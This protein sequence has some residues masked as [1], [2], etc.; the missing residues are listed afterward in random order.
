MSDLQDRIV[1]DRQ[2]EVTLGER[3]IALKRRLDEIHT[4]K[5]REGAMKE[6]T[7]ELMSVL[8]DGKVEECSDD[9]VRT[10]VRQI[11]VFSDRMVIVFRNG[12]EVEVS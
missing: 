7:M 11:R 8:E 12:V 9:L 10:F 5:A 4:E 2:N 3:I 1:H 6:K